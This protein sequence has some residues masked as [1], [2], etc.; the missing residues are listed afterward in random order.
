MDHADVDW[1]LLHVDPTLSKDL[2]ALVSYIRAFPD[3]LCAMAPVDVWL[4]PGNPEM[5]IRHANEA[6]WTHG[7]HALKI[8]PEYA[9]RMTSSRSFNEPSWTPFWDAVVGLGVPLFFTLGARPNSTNPRQGFIQE[10][11]ELRLW[12]ERHPTA[13]VCVTHGFPWRDFVDGNKFVLPPEMWEPFADSNICLELG[14]P[15]RIGDLFDY[16]Y[17]ECRPVIEAMVR[18]IGPDRLLWGTDM[19]FQ[20]RFCTY[21]Q[22]RH[23]IE[24]YRQKLISPEDLA[25]IMGGTAARILGL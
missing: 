13:T 14:F 16:P 8:D 24:K 9:Y 21:R 11:H 18:N 15:F 2:T 3:R 22:S 19:P 23:Y 25:K 1:A 6:I 7:L 4:I 17:T 10:L 20:N 5:A 12:Q